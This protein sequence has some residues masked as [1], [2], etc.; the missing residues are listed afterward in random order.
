VGDTID[1]VDG[2]RHG[3]GEGGLVE[4]EDAVGRQGWGGGLG[5]RGQREEE[6]SKR[7]AEL[8]FLLRLFMASREVDGPGD[9]DDG[10]A[11]GGNRGPGDGG[12]GG[13]DAVNP[14][15]VGGLV[16]GHGAEDGREHHAGGVDV[17]E[18]LV[19]RLF[20]CGLWHEF[21]RA[22]SAHLVDGQP[23][24]LISIERVAGGGAGIAEGVEVIDECDSAVL[25]GELRDAEDVL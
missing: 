11:V 16:E 4:E 9:G 25:E 22:G 24:L 20:D 5:Q 10:R 17:N 21:H 8:H 2:V 14:F 13:G 1:L 3:V 7:M 6:E 18:V 19:Q 12:V 15:A 23:G